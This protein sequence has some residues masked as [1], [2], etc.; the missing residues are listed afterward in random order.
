[1]DP[2]VGFSLDDEYSVTRVD[3]TVDWYNPCVIWSRCGASG[4]S[5]D[6]M[7]GRVIGWV[8]GRGLS[9]CFFVKG[10]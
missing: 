6:G 3:A 10:V 1:M 7:K 8:Y 4:R 9:V 5:V 2:E